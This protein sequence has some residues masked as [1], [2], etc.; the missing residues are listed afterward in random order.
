M[1]VSQE[2]DRQETVVRLSA[3]RKGFRREKGCQVRKKLSGGKK[4]SFRQEKG[5]RARKS[6]S[7]EKWLK[8]KKKA[9]WR[10]MTER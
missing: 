9:V 2:K 7:G 1:T 3:E 10:K 5:C 8:G 4:K 6:L